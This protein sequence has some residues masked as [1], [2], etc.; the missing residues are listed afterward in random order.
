MQRSSRG[1]G[2]T[3]RLAALTLSIALCGAWQVAVAPAPG[4]PAAD[5]SSPPPPPTGRPT[6][7]VATSPGVTAEEAVTRATAAEQKKDP[8]CVDWYAWAVLRSWPAVMVRERTNAR[9]VNWQRYHDSLTKTIVLGLKHKRL[10]PQRGLDLRIPGAAP[11][12]VVVNRYGFAWQAEDFNELQLAG[13]VPA[14]KLARHWREPGLGVPLIVLRRRKT[15]RDFHGKAM[16]FAATAVLR[17]AGDPAMLSSS[18]P[19]GTVAGILDL[20]DPLRVSELEL[21]GVVQPVAR[22]TSAPYALILRDMNR[23]NWQAFFRPGTGEA[24]G[25][26]M[27]EP[28]QQGKIPVVLVHGLL[29]DKFTW[30][31]LINDLRAVPWINTRYQ[32]WTF[33]YPTGEPFLQSAAT[34]RQVLR[35]VNAVFDPRGTDPTQQQIVLIGHSMGGLVSKLQITYSGN[36]LWDQVAS[37]PFPELRAPPQQRDAVYKMFFFEPT[38]AVKRAVFIGTPHLGSF[39]AQ[40]LYGRVGASLV[41]MPREGHDVLDSLLESNPQVFNKTLRGG[42]PTSID[43]LKADSPLLQ[44]MT[45]LPINPAVRIHSIVGNG[46]PFSD[47]TPA[48]GVVSMDSARHPGAASERFVNASHSDLPD[49]QDTV[50]EVLR[51][52]AEHLQQVDAVYRVTQP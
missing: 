6:Q 51:I 27:L 35:D 11:V 41:R 29:S 7:Q 10:D 39:W 13:D 18:T 42:I 52:L 44:G 31:P 19:P 38:P 40:S 20:Y 34:L 16:P 17:P 22:D 3:L 45:Q 48:D 15:E 33:Q 8:A 25:L 49:H 12:R 47:G 36:I 28:Y 43:L 30:I 2:A 9:D 32:I 24:I 50:A 4:A 23:D 26:R 1:I 5:T 21:E 37:R 14:G 46:T